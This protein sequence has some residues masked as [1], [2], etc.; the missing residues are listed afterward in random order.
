MVGTRSP[1]H[2]GQDEP[3]AGSDCGGQRGTLISIEV[4]Q[5]ATAV[6]Q[7]TSLDNQAP[8]N[9]QPIWKSRPEGLFVVVF[10]I[11]IERVAGTEEEVAQ[12]EAGH[13]ITQGTLPLLRQTVKVQRLLAEDPLQRLAPR[14]VP[15][16]GML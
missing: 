9:Q 15:S 3:P 13:L 12:C 16:E 8:P 1:T 14:R 4:A 11:R 2:R 6:G 10:G 5:A 7:P